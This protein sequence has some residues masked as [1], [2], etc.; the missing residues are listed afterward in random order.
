MAAKRILRALRFRDGVVDME[1]EKFSH[2]CG[3]NERRG[4]RQTKTKEFNAEIA[5]NTECAEKSP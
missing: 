1:A 2:I 5:E 3:D 4:G